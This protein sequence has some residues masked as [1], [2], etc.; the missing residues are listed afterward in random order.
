MGFNTTII[1]MNDAL[2]VIAKDTEFGAKVAQ[3]ASQY[4]CYGKK[5]V[6]ISSSGH[7]NAAT[8]VDCHHADHTSIILVGGNMGTVALPWAGGWDHDEKAQEGMLRYWAEKQGFRLVK[9]AKR[10]TDQTVLD[11]AAAVKE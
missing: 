8:V 6:D 3:A 2:H 7:C 10:K 11:L 4:G 9:K 1:I 5:P